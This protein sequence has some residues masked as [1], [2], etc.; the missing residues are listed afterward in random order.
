MNVGHVCVWATQSQCECECECA[1]EA[2]ANNS[3][4]ENTVLTI[5]T[6]FFADHDVAPSINHDLLC[7]LMRNYFR[8]AIGAAAMIEEAREKAFA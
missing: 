7:S 2:C 4:E 6:K 3:N 1:N 5:V 8:V